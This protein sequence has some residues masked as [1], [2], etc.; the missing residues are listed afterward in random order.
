VNIKRLEEWIQYVSL[1]PPQVQLRMESID[2]QIDKQDN[3]KKLP[4]VPLADISNQPHTPL[5]QT[6]SKSNDF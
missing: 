3:L 2:N 1:I 4:I 5:Q 6:L